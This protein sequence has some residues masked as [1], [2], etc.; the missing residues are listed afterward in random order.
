MTAIRTPGSELKDAL[1]PMPMIY[2]SVAAT[3]ALTLEAFWQFGYEQTEV[4]PAGSS[5]V[6][7]RL[8]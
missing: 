7:Y 2:A 8:H 5:P 4:D 6:R 3:D 1:T